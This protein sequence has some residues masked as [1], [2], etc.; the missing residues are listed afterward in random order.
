[1][2]GSKI[3]LASAGKAISAKI[4]GRIFGSIIGV[5]SGYYV[6]NNLDDIKCPRCKTTLSAILK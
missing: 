3:G 1:M 5:G 2:I 6:G 4:V